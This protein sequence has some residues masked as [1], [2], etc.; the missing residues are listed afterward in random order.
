MRKLISLMLV[1]ALSLCLAGSLAEEAQDNF[2]ISD[3]KFLYTFG[4]S[5]IAEQTVFIY[6]DN[7]FEIMDGNDS[8]KGTWTFDGETLTMTANDQTVSLKWNEAEHRFSGEY[9]GM[10]I[11]MYM[12]IEPENEEAPAGQT[13]EAPMTGAVVGGWT[14]AEDPAII[15]EINN[16]FSRA[17]DN[18]QTG[19]ITVAYA[20]YAYLGSQVVAGTNHAIL[21]RASEISK[22][23]SWAIVYIYEDLQGN[24]TVMNIADFDFGSFCTYGAE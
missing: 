18:Y 19:M 16:I 6:E 7:T 3:W 1:L 2:L 23:T 15:D 22:G 14:I 21:C 10:N 9:N 11:T 20:P 24:A 13:A 17:L 5:A 12:S 4:D 8:E